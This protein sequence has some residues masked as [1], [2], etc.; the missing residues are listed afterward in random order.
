MEKI[1]SDMTHNVWCIEIY[2]VTSVEVYQYEIHR[3]IVS[4]HVA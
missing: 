1:Q 4:Y 2:D 3:S